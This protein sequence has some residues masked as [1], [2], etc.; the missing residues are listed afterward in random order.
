MRREQMSALSVGLLLAVVA[1]LA[2]A[3][4]CL[5]VAWALW[6]FLNP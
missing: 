6:F 4:G 3:A 5:A 2:A 1:G